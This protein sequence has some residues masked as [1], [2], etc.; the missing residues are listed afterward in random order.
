MDHNQLFVYL[1]KDSKNSKEI[2][3]ITGREEPNIFSKE[4][5]LVNMKITL[6]LQQ[7]K[8]Y[9][10]FTLVPNISTMQAMQRHNHETIDKFFLLTDP[11]KEL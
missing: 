4:N 9:C 1:G 10:S 3:I 11:K 2:L 8:C 6:T 7:L 5:S